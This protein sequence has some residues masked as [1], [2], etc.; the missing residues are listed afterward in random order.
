VRERGTRV[1]ELPIDEFIVCC[2]VV[3]FCVLIVSFVVILDDIVV[4][5]CNCGD[6]VDI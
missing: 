2:C 3:T 5:D 1:I 6:G 4:G